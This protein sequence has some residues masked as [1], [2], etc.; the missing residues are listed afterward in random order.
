MLSYIDI[1]ITK[2]LSIFSVVFILISIVLIWLMFFYFSSPQISSFVRISEQKFILEDFFKESFLIVEL[3]SI[4]FV[5][6]LVSL[7][8]SSNIN[9]FDAYFISLTSKPFFIIN[10]IISFLII[11]L[12]YLMLI[13]LGMIIIYIISFKNVFYLNFIV[14]AFIFYYLFMLIYFGFSYL[15]FLFFNNYFIFLFVFLLY[16]F[17]KFVFDFRENKGYL[18]PKIS[19]NISEK[20]I[21]FN[22]NIIYI[23]IYIVDILVLI[24]EIYSLKDLKC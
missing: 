13:F 21:D 10:K 15:F 2:K 12:V 16:F 20:V 6:L 24:I 23:I 3:F 22:A 18:L 1:I 4:L 17:N 8:I 7:E 9:H 19:I 14:K 5:V 11:M